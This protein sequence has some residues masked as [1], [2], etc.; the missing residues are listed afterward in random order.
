[1]P[2]YDLF[3]TFYD[4]TVERVYRPYRAE[5]AA[6]LALRP[7]QAVL[8]LAC[9]TGP[10]LEHLVGED[11]AVFAVDFSAGMLSRARRRVERAGW[12]GVHCLQRDARA[13]T[14][15]DLAEARGGPVQLDAVLTTLGLSVIPD[16]E[17]VLDSTWALLPPGG[18]YAIFD[19]YTEAWVPTTSLVRLLAR[20][21]MT[22]RTWERLEALG[23]TV[24][25]RF[26][27]GSPHVHGGRP[28]LAVGIKGAGD[29]E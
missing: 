5:A 22:R 13:L 14:L 20:A 17:R 27:A 9:G 25:H 6:A 3:A 2:W 21:D 19:I 26:L 29:Q 1:M 18:R 24:E 11:R 23:A 16:W 15:D 28:F 10:N 4:H 7:G 12:D 8:D